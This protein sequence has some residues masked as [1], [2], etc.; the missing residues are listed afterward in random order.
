[1]NITNYTERE[2]PVIREMLVE[3]AKWFGHSLLGE[4][5]W[6]VGKPTDNRLSEF[7]AVPIK[8]G[9]PEL[10]HFRKDE[11]NLLEGWLKELSIENQCKVLSHA[12]ENH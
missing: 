1:M 11:G 7:V 10:W 5:D 3:Q 2:E 6:H 12:I 4:T 9:G 8:D